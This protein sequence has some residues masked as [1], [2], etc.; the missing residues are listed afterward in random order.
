MTPGRTTVSTMKEVSAHGPHHLGEPFPPPLP[1]QVPQRKQKLNSH[2]VSCVDCRPSVVPLEKSSDRQS[3]RQSTSDTSDEW[4]LVATELSKKLLATARKR[5]EAV[6]E[7]SRLRQT[8]SGAFFFVIIESSIY[9]HVTL[10][11]DEF[12]F[13]LVSTKTLI[14]TV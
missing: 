13:F 7:A 3:R 9:N 1:P 4:R 11:S 10:T 6:V 2:S 8:I 5:D 14:R 12:S